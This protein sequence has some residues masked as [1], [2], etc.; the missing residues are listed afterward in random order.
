MQTATD[1]SAYRVETLPDGGIPMSF[2]VKQR[3]ANP[4]A[5]LFCAKQDSGPVASKLAENR[6]PI[7]LFHVK[8]SSKVAPCV[9]ESCC[10]T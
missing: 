9:R 10:F 3:A 4:E 1:R 5:G 2:H 7:K 6:P 8:Q